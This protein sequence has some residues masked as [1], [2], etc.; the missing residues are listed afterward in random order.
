M[1]GANAAGAAVS[2]KGAPAFDFDTIHD[3]SHFG[4]AKWA[5]QWDEF[6]PLVEGDSLLSLWTA[7]MDFRAPETVIARLREA[8]DHRIYGYTRRDPRHFD[9]INVGTL[10][11][12]SHSARPD[13]PETAPA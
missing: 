5:N 2:Q 9:D 6:S 11:S 7:D 1:S 3:R 10:V 4:S 13:A 12:I 8:V